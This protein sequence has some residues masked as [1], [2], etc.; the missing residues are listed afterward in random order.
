VGVVYAGL[1]EKDRAFKSLEPGYEKRSGT[2]AYFK[3][4]PFWDNPRSDPRYTDL[5]RWMELPQ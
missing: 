5:L 3:T 2:M 4:D 1:G